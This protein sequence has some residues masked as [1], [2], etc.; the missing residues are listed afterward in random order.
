ML[1]YTAPENDWLSRS[2]PLTESGHIDI[3]ALEIQARANRSRMIGKGFA[4]L[5]RLWRRHP[6]APHQVR[7]AGTVQHELDRAAL[8]V[9]RL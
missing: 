2:L 7:Q 1:P 5:A 4:W 9:G 8:A 3:F 6:A